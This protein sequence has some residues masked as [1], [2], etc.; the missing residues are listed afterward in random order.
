MKKNIFLPIL[1]ILVFLGIT[2]IFHVDNKNKE[3]TGV[4]IITP[5]IPEEALSKV[6]PAGTIISQEEPYHYKINS[7]DYFAKIIR[8]NN[9]DL[10]VIVK[11]ETQY[12]SK[13]T[14]YNNIEE[15]HELIR[16]EST[17]ISNA[18]EAFNKN[19]FQK[20]ITGDGIGE[21]FI[22]FQST[23]YGLNGYTVLH[24]TNNKLET[25]TIGGDP[26]INF[27]EI[28]QKNGQVSLAS[29]SN[30]FKGKDFY[31]LNGNN[32]IYKRSIGFFSVPTVYSDEYEVRIGDVFGEKVVDR[33]KGNIFTDSFAPYE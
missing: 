5:N 19:F 11:N 3:N 6:F 28:E 22:L 24:H 20:D 23:G 13:Y 33:K 17:P 9:E 4:P 7:L 26:L 29:H 25:I 27:D 18:D 32:L 30:G 14:I 8:N 31:E 12:S 1:V 10:L 2:F 16:A 21:I 15:P